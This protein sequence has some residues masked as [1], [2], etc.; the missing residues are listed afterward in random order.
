VAKHVFTADGAN[1]YI[2]QRFNPS[3]LDRLT[4]SARN[5]AVTCSIVT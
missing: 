1:D 2:R 5:S 3:V 4:V